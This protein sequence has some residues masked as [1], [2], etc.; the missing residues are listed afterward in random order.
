[1]KPATVLL[2]C[3]VLLLAATVFSMQ[4][5]STR[6]PG[7]DFSKL[8]TFD[9][10]EIERPPGDVLREDKEADERIRKAIEKH[11]KKNGFERVTIGEPDFRVAY[12]AS[13]LDWGGTGQWY[14][15]S[16]NWKGTMDRTI[17]TLAEGTLI[18]DLVDHASNEIVWRGIGTDTLDPERSGKIIDKS[19]STMIRIFMR[20]VDYK[21]ARKK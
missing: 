20:D 8:K 4:V 6:E 3:A 11:L 5:E 7:F 16:Q 14:G 12:Y 10:Q 18:I 19:V 15:S 9:F 1:M 17:E 13:V 2:F 21:K